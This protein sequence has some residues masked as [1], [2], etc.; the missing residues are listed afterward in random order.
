MFVKYVNTWGANRKPPAKDETPEPERTAAQHLAELI[1]EVLYDAWGEEVSAS[2]VGDRLL[3]TLHAESHRGVRELL[4]M[5]MAEK[6]GESAGLKTERAV[7]KKLKE[8]KLNTSEYEAT[9]ISS[10]LAGICLE[11]GVGLALG[12]NLAAECVEHHVDLDFGDAT[13]WDALQRTLKI[14]RDEDLDLSVGVRSG[15][16]AIEMDCESI[17]KGYRVYRIDELLK[18][19]AASYERQRTKT[20][21]KNGYEGSLREEGGNRVVVDSLY[22]LLEA[23]KHSAD[24]FVYG[25]RLLVRGSAG[26]IDAATEIL[27]QMGWEEPRD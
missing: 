11:A 8:K 12:S 7:L 3:Y 1:D 21:R 4:D 13:C 20:G 17:S 5:L 9:P 6:G 22:D 19:L 26:D 15:A 16:V 18:K 24:C 27:K 25:D 10:V 2:V 14:L 23:G